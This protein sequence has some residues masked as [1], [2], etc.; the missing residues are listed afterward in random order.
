MQKKRWVILLILFLA[1]VNNY[2]DRQALSVLAPV[3]RDEL[4]LSSVDYS[5]I[6]NAF[7]VAYAIMYTGSGYL[8]DLLGG[9]RGVTICITAWSIATALHATAMGFLSLAFYRFILGISEPGLYPAGV[10]VVS[11]LFSAR[12][13]ALAIGLIVGGTSVGA[14]IAPIVV[15]WLH[16]NFGWRTAF[17]ATG[18][19][20]LIVLIAWLLTYQPKD[21]EGIQPGDEQGEEKTMA[22]YHWLELFRLPPLW[23]FL[24]AR[25]LSDAVWYFLLF[26]LP[27]YLV[28]E[29]GFTVSLLGKTAW[30]PYIGVDIGIL[31]G[32]LA[33]GAI[34]RRGGGVLRARKIIAL[35]AGVIVPVSIL[36]SLR[37]DDAYAIVSL[38]GIAVFGMGLWFST[39][40]ALPSDLFPFGNVASV[41]GMGGTAGAV[42]GMAF[43]GLVGIL[44]DSGLYTV[45]FWL[46]SLMYPLA[47]LTMVIFLRPVE[48]LQVKERV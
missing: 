31:L 41:Y 8:V 1:S 2:M 21:E 22:S 40:H 19:S 9:R 12:H 10:K 4:N 20:G 35:F 25:G 38:L 17:L 45:T 32:A 43:M 30:I 5:F 42:A 24:V 34:I 16:L 39:M 7:L 46:V 23:I 6:V 29:R 11:R 48:G 28:E 26:W 44:A 14:I 13:R 33:A 36:A 37:V 18:L 15:V 47:I 3:L 27:D